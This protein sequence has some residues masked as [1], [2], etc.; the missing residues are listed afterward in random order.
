M[1]QVQFTETHSE[2]PQGRQ[3]ESGPYFRYPESQESGIRIP[4]CQIQTVH[5]QPPPVDVEVDA[6]DTAIEPRVIFYLNNQGTAD[7]FL[8][9]FGTKVQQ[10]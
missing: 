5:E 1:H 2:M 8:K 7:Q 4:G 6:L 3:A 9:T 10:P